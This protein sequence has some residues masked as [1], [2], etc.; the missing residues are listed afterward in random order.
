MKKTSCTI[1]IAHAIATQH[2]RCGLPSMDDCVFIATTVKGGKKNTQTNKYVFHA[3][4]HA[5]Q[6]NQRIFMALAFPPSSYHQ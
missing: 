3:H 6:P 1:A 4:I 5:I 2:R